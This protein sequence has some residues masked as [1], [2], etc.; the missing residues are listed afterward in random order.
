[1]HKLFWSALKRKQTYKEKMVWRE[2]WALT[3]ELD[4]SANRT[5][6]RRADSAKCVGFEWHWKHILHEE[7]RRSLAAPNK[8]YPSRSTCHFGWAVTRRLQWKKGRDCRRRKWKQQRGGKCCKQNGWNCFDPVLIHIFTWLFIHI[9]AIDAI[10][11]SPTI[12]MPLHFV[13][14]ISSKLDGSRQ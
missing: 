4:L 3:R 12:R 10:S 2:Q 6:L 11:F 5:P 8:N 7:W 9:K 14:F 1:M 13:W